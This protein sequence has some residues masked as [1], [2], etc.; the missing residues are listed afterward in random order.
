MIFRYILLAGFLIVICRVAITQDP[1][2]LNR[3]LSQINIEELSDQQILEIKQRAEESGLSE[4][5]MKAAL[6]ARGFP[7]N[8]ISKFE[9]R[10]KLIESGLSV[11]DISDRSRE[12]D[13]LQTM[14]PDE[15]TVEFE[16]GP[17]SRIFG[18]E[19]FRKT[20][21]TFEPSLNLPTPMNYQVGPGDELILDIWGASQQTYQLPIS[22]EG[23][24]FIENL[25]PIQ[26]SGLTIEKASDRIIGRLNS[27]YSGLSSPNQ[28]TYAQVTLGNARSITIHLLGEVN[29]PG[30]YTLSAFATIFNALYA[31]GGPTING[32]FRNIELFRNNELVAVLD[33]YDFLMSGKLDNNIRLQDQD[34]IKVNPY[35]SRVDLTGEVKR[36]GLY[37]LTEGETLDNIISFSGGFANRAYQKTLTVYRNTDIE[38]KIV[39]VSKGDFADF[40]MQDGD[41]IP[42]SPILKRFENRV[43]ING[44][45]YRPGEYSLSDG[46]TLNEL[47]DRA[48]GLTDDAFLNRALIYR[49]RNDLSLEIIPVNLNSII[50]NE[51]SFTLM[52][53]DFVTIASIF[54]LREDYFVEILGEVNKEG[55]FPFMENTSLEDIVVMAGGL[56]ESAS[57]AK[58]EVARRIKSRDTQLQNGKISEIFH[59]NID[60]DLNISSEASH[61]ELKPFDQVFIRK[62]PG[63]EEPQSIIMEGEVKYPGTY[64]LSNKSD[65][66]S[67]LIER[68]GGLTFEAYAEGAQLMRQIEVNQEQRQE[69][70]GNLMSESKDSLIIDIDEN[71]EQP[72]GIDLNQI[73][74]NPGSKFDLLLQK[75]DRLII[76]KELQTVRL[77]GAL[78]F[79]ITVRY[80]N[81]YTFGKYISMSGGFANNA[82]KNKAYVIYANGSVDKT[83]SFMFIRNYPRV[84][85]G[86]EIVVPQKQLKE[87]MT[88]GEIIGITSAVSSLALIIVTII[89]SVSP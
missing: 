19:L 1:S 76:P 51:S 15:Y 41:S 4:S 23:N 34:V 48:E 57:L 29:L 9:E 72:I 86:A 63:Y 26:V 61:F 25:G 46:L 32:S 42:V 68:A 60:K 73:L 71:K 62:S 36:P 78:L 75:D 22:P 53:E 20:E 45:V 12:Q 67:D 11:E 54:D 21:L 87:K 58:V 66:I 55:I 16:P 89:N 84:A 43:T 6:I 52:K 80:D 77:S 31:S 30:S 85:P 8:E 40:V 14:Y 28:N 5:Q 24:I 17:E 37:E 65:R 2:V 82:K 27:I 88:T 56:K 18:Y 7:P 70:L 74:K 38:R 50:N 39:N 64:N 47:I 3:D 10:L 83:R 33:I 79:P 35:L 49:T 69:I 81:S 59:F 13:T 44:A